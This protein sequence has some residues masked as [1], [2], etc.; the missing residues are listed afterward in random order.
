MIRYRKNL[1]YIRFKKML[2]YIQKMKEYIRKR[3]EYIQQRKE[4]IQNINEYIQVNKP[5][6][7]NENYNSVIPLNLYV[8]WHTKTLPSKMKENYD[9]LV[10][11]N[12]EFNHFLYDEQDCSN[13]IKENFDE[14]VLNAYTKLNPKAYKADLWR[15]CVLYIN[16][17]IYLDIKYKCVNNFKLISLTESEYFVRDRPH[18]SVYNALMICFP[19]N[20]VLLQII[21]Q[22]VKNT[23]SNFYGENA[24]FPTGP[25]LIGTFCSD[26]EIN[27][28]ELYFKVFNFGQY[29]EDII[30]KN[31]NIL[32]S[33][34]EY[35]EE[36]QKLN[37]KHYSQLWNERNIYL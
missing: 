28:M 21:D 10:Q 1:K 23:E 25:S 33:Y 18:K 32:E 20:P 14:N 8:C 27:D 16:G 37:E 6:M 11:Q 9:L 12:P 5:F 29:K 19:G 4:H 22:I 26:D 7:L 34:S 3:N 17:G 36:Q 15:Y 24:L 35:R 13:F 30:Y 2:I 31:T